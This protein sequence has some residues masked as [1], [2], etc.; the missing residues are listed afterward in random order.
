M[1]RRKLKPFSMQREPH[2]GSLKEG[3]GRMRF[4]PS[5]LY[6][7]DDKGGFDYY[8]QSTPPEDMRSTT[9]EI[10]RNLIY[11]TMEDPSLSLTGIPWR[12]L[13]RK[14]NPRI[15][16]SKIIYCKTYR[17]FFLEGIVE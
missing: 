1:Y 10:L 7:I 2:S 3:L 13:A 11:K 4:T 14:R 9:G 8:I 17:M 5:A 15:L 6:A 16:N 12:T